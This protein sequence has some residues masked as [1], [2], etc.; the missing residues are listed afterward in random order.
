VE[1]YLEGGFRPVE[2]TDALPSTIVDATSLPLRVVREGAVSLERLREVVPGLLD[3]QGN[4]PEPL[5][6]AGTEDAAET[7]EAAETGDA[8]GT[9]AAETEDAAGTG[10]DPAGRPGAGDKVSG[11]E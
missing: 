4:A 3:L 7:E 5:G 6:A 11:T 2:G 1:V 8:A 10:E 9:D